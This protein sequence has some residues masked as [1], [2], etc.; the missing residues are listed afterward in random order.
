LQEEFDVFE[1]DGAVLAT[2]ESKIRV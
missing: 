1:Q 2:S